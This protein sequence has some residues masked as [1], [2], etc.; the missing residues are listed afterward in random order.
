MRYN[1]RMWRKGFTLIELL[2]VVAIIGILASV[3]LASLN[4]ARQK[5]QI[6]AIKSNL[7]NMSDQ[8]EISYDTNGN[9]GGISGTGANANFPDTTCQGPIAGMAQSI[10]NTGAKA[11]CLSMNVSGWGESNQR[12]GATGLIYSASPPVQAWSATPAGVVTWNAKGVNT[13]GTFVTGND[14]TMTWDQANTACN[15]AGARLPTAEELKTLADAT[16]VALGSADCTVVSARNP[17]GFVAA[18]YWSGT[19]VPSD[20]SSAYGVNFNSGSL[21]TNV[22]TY[23]NYVHCVR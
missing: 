18:Y 13:D 14:V 16:C 4:S 2:V 17:P 8:M 9:Y 15:L 5:G 21:G 22:K 1:V 23:A 10:I 20:S 11:R 3:V 7:R 12:W 6:A 19:T